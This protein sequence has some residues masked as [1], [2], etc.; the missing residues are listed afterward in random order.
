[1]CFSYIVLKKL[2]IIFINMFLLKQRKYIAILFW[3]FDFFFV[4]L[5]FDLRAL[6]LQSRRFTTWATLPVGFV[7]VILKM[8]SWELFVWAGLQLWSYQALPPKYRI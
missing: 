7:P 3:E 2:Y 4:N 5:E 6:C 1:M 8:E